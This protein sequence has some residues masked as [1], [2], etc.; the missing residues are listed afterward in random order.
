MITRADYMAGKANHQTYYEQFETPALK[1]AVLTLIGKK[2]ILAS[3]DPHLNDI[4]LRKWDQVSRMCRDEIMHSN[5][6]LNGQPTYCLSDGVC[7]AKAYAR[8]FA[9]EMRA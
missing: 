4:P 7:A 3:C 5:L 9:R 6:E 2:A 8:K 1:R